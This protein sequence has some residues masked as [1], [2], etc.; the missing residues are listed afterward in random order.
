MRVFVVGGTRFI[1]PAVVRALSEVGH[2]V[3]VYHRGQSRAQ[4]PAGTA[5]YLGDRMDAGKMGQAIREHGTQ[6]VLDMCAFELEHHQAVPADL[7]L[8]N[9]RQPEFLIKLRDGK[10]AALNVSDEAF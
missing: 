3:A 6:A 1:G 8:V 2:S 9:D 4:L 5:E 7:Y 10:L